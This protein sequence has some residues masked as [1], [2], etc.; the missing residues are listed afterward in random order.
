M[1]AYAYTCIDLYIRPCIESTY[2]YMSLYNHT[3][4]MRHSYI[5]IYE[6]LMC[7]CV[8]AHSRTVQKEYI[9]VTP[10][11]IPITILYNSYTCIHI[12]K[13]AYMYT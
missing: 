2:V 1:Y 11:A 7:V 12:H 5:Y 4:I 8:G 3:H 6:C 10:I 13:Q 9:I